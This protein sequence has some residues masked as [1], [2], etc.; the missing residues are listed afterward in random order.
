MPTTVRRTDDPVAVLADAGAF[1]AA[2]PV[3]LNVIVSLLETRV[4]HPE[5]GDYWI[6][7]RDGAVVGVVF[8]SPV[9]Y[10]PVVSPMD[11]D[12]VT[13]VVDAMAGADVKLP[14]VNGDATTSARF[15]GAWAARTRTP[16][17]PI[18]AQ[19]IFEVPA[20]RPPLAPG[21]TVR[22]ATNADHELLV[23]WV[24]AFHSEIG[25][26]PVGSAATIVERRTAEG[27]FH[28]WDHGGAVAFA[29]TTE[30]SFGVVRIGPV[31]TPPRC[32]GRGYAS[33]LV[34][35]LSQGVLDRG[36]R[37]V[38]YTDLDNPT[39]NAIYQRIGYEP[40]EEALR[41]AFGH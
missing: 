5:P 11:L 15:A 34:A 36:E 41:Y 38:L 8:R 30:P 1:L 39:S 14:G 9:D 10:Y 12:A 21:G 27:L 25:D 20:V 33:A 3:R 16:A 2:D 24:E 40:V 13:V 18:H 26:G 28:V 35:E 37:C 29:G 31:Y 4:R 22:T 6:V 7:E 23:D 19:R 17:R 32:R